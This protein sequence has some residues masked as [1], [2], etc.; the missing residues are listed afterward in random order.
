LPTTAGAF[1]KTGIGAFVAKLNASGSALVYLTYVVEPSSC[2]SCVYSYPGNKVSALA[3]DASGSV[4]IAG[5]TNDPK[6]RVTVGALQTAYS[7]SADSCPTTFQQPD[8]FVAKLR[9]DGSGMAWATYLGGQAAESARSIALDASGT[10]WMTGNTA[11]PDFPSS[12]ESGG[13]FLVQLDSSGSA[14]LYAARFPS[15]TV[16]Q[17]VAIDADRVLH[18]AGID[19][20]ISTVNSRYPPPPRI[21]SVRNAAGGPYSRLLAP[22]E[23]IS[24]Y[25]FHVGPSADARADIDSGLV[26]KSLSGVEVFIGGLAAPVQ[27]VSDSQIDAIVPLKLEARTAAAIRISFD[28]ATLPDFPVIIASAAPRIFRNAD[29]S[30]VAQNEDG[31][32]NSSISPAKMGSVVTIWATGTGVIPVADGMIE[33]TERNDGCCQVF[34]N[35]QPTEVLYAGSSPGMVAGMTR[36][37]F[38][39]P[40]GVNT[41][42]IEIRA[43]GNAS[44]RS[45][46][47]VWF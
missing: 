12:G 5:S 42:S 10:V 17:S 14:L 15:E 13:D 40:N 22:G 33:T 24:I 41:A 45:Y 43:A 8:A 16:A 9:P 4:F 20:S 11:S 18:L 3:V 26:P 27:Y 29:G 1:L 23:L 6:L 28:D 44:D 37:D 38:R 7:G 25:G 39:V 2:R 32:S 35:G 21:M 31:S 36:I 19:G 30:A 47:Y 34:V 46:L